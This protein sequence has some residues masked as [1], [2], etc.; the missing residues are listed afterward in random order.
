MANTNTTTTAITRQAEVK[1][2]KGLMIVAGEAEFTADE[3]ATITGRMNPETKKYL[4]TL[5]KEFMLLDIAELDLQLEIKRA[6]RNLKDTKEFR[7]LQQ[8]KQNLRLL[9]EQR[10]EIRTKG[11]GVFESVLGAVRKG[12]ALYRKLVMYRAAEEQS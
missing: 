9:R 11:K 2:E 6:Q 8:H 7:I 5:N 12:T 1:S 4:S 10:Y 3:L